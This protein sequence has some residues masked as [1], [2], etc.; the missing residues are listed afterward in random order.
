MV[1]KLKYY[2]SKFC[3][4]IKKIFS[5]KR[6]KKYGIEMAFLD[7][8]IFFMHRKGNRLEHFLIRKKDKIVQKYLYKNYYDVILKIKD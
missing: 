5:Y 1:S 8:C 6:L 3:D 2:L 4:R 7:L